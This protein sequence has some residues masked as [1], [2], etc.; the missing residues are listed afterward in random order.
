MDFPSLAQWLGRTRETS[1]VLTPRLVDAYRAT[2]TP[3]LADM[4]PGAAPPAIHW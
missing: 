2:L 1:D 4:E 3:H